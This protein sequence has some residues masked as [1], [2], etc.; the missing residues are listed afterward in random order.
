MHFIPIST[1]SEFITVFEPQRLSSPPKGDD[2]YRAIKEMLRGRHGFIN[3]RRRP[4][5]G[6]ERERSCGKD[7]KEQL[8]A[9][10]LLF[11]HLSVV[12][13]ITVLD[14]YAEVTNGMRTFSRHPPSI[15]IM[16]SGSSSEKLKQIL[17]TSCKTMLDGSAK[18]RCWSGFGPFRRTSQ[19]PYH[20]WGASKQHSLFKGLE[21]DG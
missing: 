13:C 2:I 6:R 19:L 8:T 5:T 3:C 11:H 20:S 12:L 14:E 18:A 7:E 1:L 4:C 17:V 21:E 9:H 15:S 16:C 10:L